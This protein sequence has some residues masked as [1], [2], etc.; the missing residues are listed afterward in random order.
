MKKCPKCGSKNVKF[1]TYLGVKTIKCNN[2]NFDESSVYET[3]PEEK[4]SQKAR[5]DT[6][7]TRKAALKRTK[8][9][10]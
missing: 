2:C 4:T 3:Y 8:K 1:S 7:F 5:E 10:N 9:R 6:Q